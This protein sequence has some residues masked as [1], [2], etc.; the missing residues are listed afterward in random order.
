MLAHSSP[1]ALDVSPECRL[2]KESAWGSQSKTVRDKTPTGL[3]PL[4]WPKARLS[5]IAFHHEAKEAQRMF[6]NQ[7]S[8]DREE[9]LAQDG[10]PL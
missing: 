2:G 5:A 10:G 6:L 1:R 9:A 8:I 4:C 7:I 3:H